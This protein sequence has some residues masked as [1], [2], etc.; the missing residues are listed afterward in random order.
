MRLARGAGSIRMNSIEMVGAKMGPNKEKMG[1]GM[2]DGCCS[3]H[4]ADR[5]TGGGCAGELLADGVGDGVPYHPSHL[6]LVIPEGLPEDPS[7]TK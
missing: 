3:G 6:A 1:R 4:S 5:V 2:S 7:F